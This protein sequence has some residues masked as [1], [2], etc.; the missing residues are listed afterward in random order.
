MSVPEAMGLT[1]GMSGGLSN[2]LSGL[3]DNPYFSAGAG[4][5][6][7]GAGMAVLRKGMRS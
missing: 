3:A 4:I 7:L 6:G 2:G 5:F 1:G